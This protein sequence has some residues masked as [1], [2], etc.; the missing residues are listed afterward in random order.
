MIQSFHDHDT[1]LIDNNQRR[2]KLPPDMQN[3]GDGQ[4]SLERLIV[5][6]DSRV[7]AATINGASVSSRPIGVPPMSASSI[8]NKAR[9][10]NEADRLPAR[11]RAAN[12]PPA[13]GLNPGPNEQG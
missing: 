5:A 7:S 6:A 10:T 9:T 12:H 13:H 2:R 8:T 11:R 3:D 1:V 4:A